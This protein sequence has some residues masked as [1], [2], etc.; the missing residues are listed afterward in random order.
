VQQQCLFA[1]RVAKLIAGLTRGEDRMRQ[2]RNRTKERRHSDEFA[3]IERRKGKV[4]M[5]GQIALCAV[6]LAY[7][8]CGM[9]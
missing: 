5:Y 9:D 8:A 1:P 4:R 2:K 3:V 7:L 6:L